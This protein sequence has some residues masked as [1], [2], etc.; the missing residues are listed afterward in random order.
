M[1]YTVTAHVSQAPPTGIEA[2]V[3]ELQSTIIIYFTV[4]TACSKVLRTAGAHYY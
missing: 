3:C 4:R 1:L 2:R